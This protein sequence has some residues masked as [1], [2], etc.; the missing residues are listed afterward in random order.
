MS[1]ADAARVLDIDE[2]DLRGYCAGKTHVP[3]YILLALKGVVDLGV[4]P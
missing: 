1:Q 4:R 3:R 2:A